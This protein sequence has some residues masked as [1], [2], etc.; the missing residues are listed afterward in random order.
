MGV[1]VFGGA[2]VGGILDLPAV[3]QSVGIRRSNGDAEYCCG[4]YGQRC[5]AGGVASGIPS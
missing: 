1:A 5:A 3:S 4:L 2:D